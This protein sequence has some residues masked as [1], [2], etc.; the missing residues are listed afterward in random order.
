MAQ[1]GARNVYWSTGLVLLTE[2]QYIPIIIFY[3]RQLSGRLTWRQ[4]LKTCQHFIA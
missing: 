2:R 3:C 4:M 1:A